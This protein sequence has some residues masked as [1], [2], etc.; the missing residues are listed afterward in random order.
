MCAATFLDLSKSTEN[1]EVPLLL[2]NDIYKLKLQIV[3]SELY[4]VL[5]MF[6]T[7]P[8]TVASDVREFSKLEL[9]KNHL[10]STLSQGKLNRLV[11]LSIRA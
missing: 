4:S 7:I 9:I 2:L 1:K 6:I 10:R 5:R 11:M 8:M 3:F